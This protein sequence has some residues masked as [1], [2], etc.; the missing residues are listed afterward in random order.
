MVGRRTPPS[1]SAP[2]PAVPAAALVGTTGQVA[3]AMEA[4]VAETDVEG[5]MPATAIM[6]G[7]SIPPTR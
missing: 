7:Y 2:G 4:W 6:P 3:D 5:F 1:T